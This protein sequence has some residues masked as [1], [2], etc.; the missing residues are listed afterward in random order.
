LIDK[1]ILRDVTKLLKAKVYYIFRPGHEYANGLR[2]EHLYLLKQ[3]GFQ[4]E[5]FQPT[6]EEYIDATIGH[7]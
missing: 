1:K 7:R 6:I 4:I 2:E 5:P 3:N